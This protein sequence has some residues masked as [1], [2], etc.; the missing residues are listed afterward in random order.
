VNRLLRHSVAALLNAAHPDVDY[1]FTEAEVIAAVQ[2][3]FASGDFDAASD[4]FE[5]A[6]EQGCDDIKD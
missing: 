6:N 4:A 2:D 1:D 3:A 5:E